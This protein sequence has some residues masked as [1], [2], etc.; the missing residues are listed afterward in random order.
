MA[1]TYNMPDI[2]KGDTFKDLQFTITINSVAEDLTG[3]AIAC[4]FRKGSKTGREIKSLTVGSGITI[5]DATNGIFQINAFDLGVTFTAGVY[6]YDIEFTD[7]SNVIN[8][9]ISGTIEV[10]QDV[11]F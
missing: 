5:T 6:Y 1:E 4:K 10:I 2:V 11:S 3:Y 8:T 7:T 9:W